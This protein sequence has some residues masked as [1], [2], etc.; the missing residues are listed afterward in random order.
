MKKFMKK[1]KT[2]FSTK[3]QDEG[4][5]GM[6]EYILLVVVVVGLVFMLKSPLTDQVTKIKDQLA[7]SIGNILGN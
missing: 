1:L 7:S 2:H 5:Q 6:L 4:G 3:L